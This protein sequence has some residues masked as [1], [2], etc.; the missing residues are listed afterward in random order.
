MCRATSVS[1]SKTR[2]QGHRGEEPELRS[3]AIIDSSPYRRL[4]L[5]AQ[6]F[7]AFWRIESTSHALKYTSNRGVHVG[8][9]LVGSHSS[10]S[11]S[12]RSSAVPEPLFIVPTESAFG[13]RNSAAA[14]G[15]VYWP[16]GNCCLS[17]RL[18]Q[19]PDHPFRSP[20]APTMAGATSVDHKRGFECENREIDLQNRF[21][22]AGKVLRNGSNNSQ[23]QSL[24]HYSARPL[25]TTR[26]SITCIDCAHCV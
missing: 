20:P 19:A 4:N 21:W 15:L 23:K 1:R 2:N 3:A 25:A 14:V 12:C 22:N 6:I 16:A 7:D 17:N 24:R 8:D 10:I 11:R 9:D 13:L 18:R 5:L 26:R